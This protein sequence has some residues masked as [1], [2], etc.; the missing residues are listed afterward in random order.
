MYLREI[1]R[2][3]E[4]VPRE[5]FVKE[6]FDLGLR[7]GYGC[8]SLVAAV[9]VGDR[10]V[11]FEGPRVP[12]TSYKKGRRDRLS[13]SQ[14]EMLSNVVPQVY[15]IE[16]AHVSAVISTDI[17]EDDRYSI[18][19]VANELEN[20]Y[21]YKMQWE[22]CMM[23]NFSIHS[24]NFITLMTPLI[25]DPEVR[26]SQM[27]W[28]LSRAI[29]MDKTLLNANPITVVAAIICLAKRGRLRAAREYRERIF[30][31]VIVQVGKEYEIPVSDLLKAFT[32]TMSSSQESDNIKK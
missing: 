16:L 9:E 29:C 22:I 23:N 27:F 5:E 24:R 2:L 14:V 8:D 15:S 25:W 20:G 26:V 6:I 18:D 17:G 7:L 21:V 1:P 19:Q 31:E 10:F 4:T 13:P 32:S 28:D 12:Y 11:S 30:K 3:P